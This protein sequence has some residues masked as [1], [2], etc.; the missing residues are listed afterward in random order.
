[1]LW[2]ESQEVTVNLKEM[3]LCLDLSGLLLRDVFYTG[4]GVLVL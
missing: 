3:F 2:F 1:M 4:R